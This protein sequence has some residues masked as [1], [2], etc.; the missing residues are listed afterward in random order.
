VP[1][2]KSWAHLTDIQRACE[3]AASLTQQLLAFSR[4]QV[5][6]PRSLDLNAVVTETERLLRRL[7]GEDIEFAVVLDPTLARVSADPTLLNQV[8][9]NLVV[10]ARDAMPSGGRLT[11]ET[12]NVQIDPLPVE[13]PTK[14]RSGSYVQLTVSDTGIGMDTSTQRRIFEP[15]FTTK[16]RGKGSGLGLS[17]VYGIV[18]Q[19]GGWISVYSEPNVGSTFKVYLPPLEGALVQEL[20]RSEGGTSER[21]HETVLL[22]EDQA[23][24]RRLVLS[25]LGE[26]GYHMLEADCG[27]RALAVAAAYGG[28]IDLLLT[29]VVMPGMSGRALSDKLR[30]THP[31]LKVLFMSGYTDDVVVR[32][33]VLEHGVAFLQKPFSPVELSQKLRVVLGEHR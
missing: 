1:T 9:I 13:W 12:R 20:P 16:P 7:I 21:G 3:R 30:E 6:Q 5:M 23:D 25:I 27:D 22:V 26:L 14:V 31:E 18:E 19:S 11:V 2:D 15:F 33:G 32:H 4:Q 29:D 24:V 8:L 17:T 10:N 28:P